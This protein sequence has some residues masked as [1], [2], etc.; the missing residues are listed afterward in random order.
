M[1]KKVRVQVRRVY[2]APKRGDGA[3]VLARIQQ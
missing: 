1:A 2:D 3:R